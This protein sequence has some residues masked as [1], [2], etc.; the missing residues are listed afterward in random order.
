MLS[1]MTF[2]LTLSEIFRYPVK[3]CRG[4]CLETAGV[5]GRGL[6]HDRRWMVVDDVGVFLTQ[7][8]LPRMARVEARI[9]PDG[10]VLGAPGLGEFAAPLDG[11]TVRSSRP[12]TIWRDRCVVE[13]EG[14]AAASW[15]T[16]AL[17]VSCRL[18]RTGAGFERRIDDGEERASEG[19]IA[20]ADGFPFL[21]VTTGSMKELDTRLDRPVETERFRPN[22][23]VAGC[24]PFAEDTWRRIR[25]GGMTFR[26]AKPCERC[27][28]PS[29][30]PR[31]GERG[32]EP[33]V[34]LATYRRDSEGKIL[35]GQ[36]L[37]HETLEGTLRVGDRV[38]IL[39]ATPPRIAGDAAP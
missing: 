29:L 10:L 15:L 38:E 17:G 25:I 39:E 26:V 6:E 14:D 13:D 1:R 11:S 32:A 5:D 36:N 4:E 18:V 30:D 8:T 27:T 20:F 33:L 19:E 3:S 35:F 37:V 31:T 34:T 12:A 28:V 23:V 7:R 21:L 16:E 2:S 24:G 9:G 22:L